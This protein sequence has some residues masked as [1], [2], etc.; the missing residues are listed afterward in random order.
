MRAK[1]CW[2]VNNS[3]NYGHYFYC[4][5]L[6][7]SSKASC[8]VAV[9][10]IERKHTHLAFL[11]SHPLLSYKC[12]HHRSDKATST[13]IKWCL[14]THGLFTARKVV[15]VYN[16]PLYSIIYEIC[17]WICYIVFSCGYVIIMDA[18]DLF[19]YIFS[20]F[21]HWNHRWIW[22]KLTDATSQQSTTM[23][24]ERE[25][26]LRY[27]TV[28]TLYNTVN[29][30]WSTHKRHSIA[31]PKGRGMECLLWVQRATYCTD[32]STF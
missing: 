32:L 26:I 11:R 20:G 5:L 13:A 1:E 7:T 6:A 30:C 15:V 4:F 22:V 18:S 2:I 23:G 28:E 25:Y 16:N 14:L 17:A 10:S 12:P 21:R 19:H 24:E 29:F 27:S 8:G 9:V 3:M 31:R